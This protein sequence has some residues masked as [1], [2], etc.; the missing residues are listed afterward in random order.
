MTGMLQPPLHAFFH[1]ITI[2][3]VRKSILGFNVSLLLFNKMVTSHSTLS[4]LGNTHLFITT[5]YVL[6]E[7]LIRSTLL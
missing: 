5:G 3:I 4:R 6:E 7:Y 1:C 2:L